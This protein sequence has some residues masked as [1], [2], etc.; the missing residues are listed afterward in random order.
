M[1][2]LF[3]FTRIAHWVLRK[4]SDIMIKGIEVSR[5]RKGNYRLGLF[6]GSVE[7]RHPDKF[8]SRNVTEPSLKNEPKG[9]YREY[10]LSLYL[11]VFSIHIS[12]YRKIG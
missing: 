9:V 5:N 8:L 3:A 4:E 2:C 12:F 10:F 6:G 11:I 1:H 7:I